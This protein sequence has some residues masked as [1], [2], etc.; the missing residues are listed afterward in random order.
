MTSR[1][2]T[3]IIQWLIGTIVFAMLVLQV[4]AQFVVSPVIE[5]A[6]EHLISQSSKDL[7]QVDS[8]D[9]DIEYFDQSIIFNHFHL[10]FDSS[11]FEVKKDSGIARPTLA[12]V[13]IPRLEVKMLDMFQAYKQKNFFIQ[14]V[15]ISQPELY[16]FDDAELAQNRRNPPRVD[17]LYQLISSKIKGLYIDHILIEGGTF[18]LNAKGKKRHNTFSA[19]DISVSIANFRLDSTT[20]PELDRPFYADQISASVNISD[21][22]FVFPDSTYAIKAGK[23]GLS[24]QSG[25]IFAEDLELIPGSLYFPQTP[26]SNLPSSQFHIFVPRLIVEKTGFHRAYF[27]RD[28]HLGS[29]RVVEPRIRQMGKVNPDSVPTDSL[30]PKNLFA[31]ISPFFDQIIVDQLKMEK[32]NYLRISSWED[33]LGLI[34]LNGINL[35]LNHVR[36]DSSMKKPDKRLFFSDDLEL[37]LNKY[38]FILSK[39]NYI[40][41]GRDVSLS[42]IS[43]DFSAK[44][45]EFAPKAEK[46]EEAF[47]SGGDII[48]FQIPSLQLKGLNLPEAWHD[49]ILDVSTF[50]I[51]TPSVE[52]MNLPK[53]QKETVDSLAKTNLYTLVSD[54]LYSFT[55]RS[56][57]INNGKFNFNSS[58]RENENEFKAQNIHVNIR[59]F[60]LSPDA[61]KETSN[62]FY[63]ND[64]DI[65]GDIVDYS[66]ILPDSSYSIQA[67]SIGVSTADSAVFADSILIRPV[68][69][70]GQKSPDENHSEVEMMIPRVYLSGLDISQIW[71]NQ[72]LDIDSIGISK[73]RI[74]M[75][76]QVF[77]PD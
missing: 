7:Y 48:F 73:P 29:I 70:R 38:R 46:Y 10:I 42:S 30:D 61:K 51:A 66:F 53:V 20:V 13:Y 18:H 69:F 32:G 72:F 37:Q 62:P 47:R 16:L 9:I 22:S 34:G 57:R 11:K 64:I 75:E 50:S 4:I 33:S 31:K 36:L 71:F 39:N 56:F 68:A 41:T 12:D 23:L 35:N 54:F 19:K 55:I 21:Y 28:L 67:Q 65:Q 60:T 76:S 49:R 74:T 15:I 14:S 1:K 52:L 27:E 43:G 8:L 3:R 58:N 77:K 2:T 25:E 24:T 45:L 40:L 63:A 6:V 5:E 26:V 59:N 44:R 17:Q